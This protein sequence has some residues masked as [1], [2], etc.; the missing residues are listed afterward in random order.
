MAVVVEVV[1][2]TL[3]VGEGDMALLV[4]VA[5]EGEEVEDVVVVFIPRT[6]PGLRKLAITLM[7]N[8]MI[9]CGINS[10]AFAI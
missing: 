3:E 10:N 6:L 7:K 4:V 8:G 1:E 9:L 5:E 2:D